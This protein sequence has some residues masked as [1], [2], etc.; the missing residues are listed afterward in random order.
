MRFSAPV[1]T[2]PLLCLGLS[3]CGNGGSTLNPSTWFQRSGPEQVALIP[4]GGFEDK[5]D[6]RFL[7]ANVTALTSMQV[8]NGIIIKATGLPPR[9]GYWDASLAVLNG[10]DPVDGVLTYEFRVSEPQHHTN[11]GRPQQR[12]ILVGKFLSERQLRGVKTVR[13]IAAGNSRSLRR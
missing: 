6:Q 2:L 11:S 12:E 13:V 1:F 3:A 7:V 8:P 4:E 10:G 9:L 5:S